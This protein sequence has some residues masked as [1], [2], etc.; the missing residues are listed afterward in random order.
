MI[1]FCFISGIN[2]R[3]KIIFSFF[4]CFVFLHLFFVW[5]VVLLEFMLNMK[6]CFPPH[7][8]QRFTAKQGHKGRDEMDRKVRLN[9][10]PFK[11]SLCRTHWCSTVYHHQL[12]HNTFILNE[13]L[14]SL[15]QMMIILLFCI[16]HRSVSRSVDDHRREETTSPFNAC[17]IFPLCI[18]LFILRRHGS[19]ALILTPQSNRE[20][21]SEF[22]FNNLGLKIEKVNCARHGTISVTRWPCLRTVCVFL[23]FSPIVQD[24]TT[25]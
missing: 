24:C 3:R 5:T 22:Y 10:E 13:Q 23:V 9:I 6:L 1:F 4:F 7:F 8:G 19:S 14:M 17:I 16:V 18:C 25:I 21:I 2:M 11:S 15:V 20:L 12:L